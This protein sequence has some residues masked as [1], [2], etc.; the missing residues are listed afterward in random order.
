MNAR[1]APERVGQAHLADQLPNFER[2]LGPA[3]VTV[4]NDLRK[5]FRLL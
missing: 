3:S 5:S 4:A 2:H 1:S